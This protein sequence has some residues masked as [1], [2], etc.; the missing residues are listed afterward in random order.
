LKNLRIFHTADLH[1]GLQYPGYKENPRLRKN[2]IDERTCCLERMI[3]A[4]NNKNCDLF[5]IAG[6]LFDRKSIS[7]SDLKKTAN[8]I[9]NFHGTAVVILPG[10]HDFIE[11]KDKFWNEF[12]NYCNEKL[13]L[14]L[15]DLYPV[16]LNINNI[17][18]VFYPAPCKL[19]HS[20]DNMIKW[21]KNENINCSKLNIGIAHG[22]IE[23][24]TQDENQKYYPMKLNDMESCSLDMW[25]LG[26][27]HSQHPKE[28]NK[29]AKP[30]YLMPSTP[31]PDG[32][33]CRHEGYAWLI[34]ADENKNISAVS[35]QTG[36]YKFSEI[37]REI[38]FADDLQ[39]L[40]VEISQSNPERKILKVKL[41]GKLNEE[42]LESSLVKFENELREIC[43]FANVESDIKMNITEE[44]I[45]KTYQDN[46]IPYKLLTNLMK[47]P[48]NNLA[49]QLAHR[50]FQEA[51]DKNI[52]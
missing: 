27:T 20:S 25:L 42:E 41:K 24:L 38:Y 45:N 5:V 46:S 4:A 48:K 28:F 23:N 30:L 35:I 37:E 21:I 13:L 39:K 47:R 12:R 34:E 51:R 9:N 11:P 8:A 32:F 2:L 3:A 52:N 29:N 16:E 1:I 17:D 40:I 7:S 43:A 19:R 15:D 33:D 50:L 26:H 6:D 31:S 49:L 22:S 18:V 10:N 36:T 14:L 44:F